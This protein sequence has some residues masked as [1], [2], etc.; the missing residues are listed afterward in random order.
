MNTWK[1]LSK[2]Y[3]VKGIITTTP[4]WNISIYSSSNS[5]YLPITEF[6]NSLNSQNSRIEYTYYLKAKNTSDLELINQ[7]KNDVNLKT[8]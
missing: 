6:D 3:I 1:F 4:L 2:D 8:F 5:I 7:I